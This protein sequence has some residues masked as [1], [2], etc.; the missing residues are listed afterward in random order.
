MSISVWTFDRVSLTLYKFHPSMAA[1]LQRSDMVRLTDLPPSPLVFT[2]CKCLK[3]EVGKDQEQCL[4][5][6]HSTH[7]QEISLECSSC[8][9]LY[10]NHWQV[11]FRCYLPT[12]S[13]IAKAGPGRARAR[14]KFVL[15]M[16]AQ[17]LVLLAQWLSV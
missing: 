3:L 14:P 16:C 5:F 13:G 8:I 7:D 1:D 11:N 15:L 6:R 12:N 10:S 2:C 17:A 9:S 4:T